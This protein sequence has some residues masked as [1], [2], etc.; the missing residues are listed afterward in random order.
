MIVDHLVTRSAVRSLGLVCAA[1]VPLATSYLL[2][3]FTYKETPLDT[4]IHHV[5]LVFHL[6]QSGNATQITTATVTG[7]GAA[8]YLYPTPATFAASTPVSSISSFDSMLGLSPDLIASATAAM[9][10]TGPPS[11][12]KDDTFALSMT[13]RMTLSLATFLEGLG[14]RD[15]TQ[16]PGYQHLIT[17]QPYLAPIVAFIATHQTLAWVVSLLHLW[18]AAELLFY[19]HFW[20]RLARAQQVDRVVK[21]PRSPEERR[22]LFERCMET[23]ERGAGAR[24]WVETWFDT[25]RT[26]RPART[27]DIARSNM[28]QWLAWA[29]WAS[30]IEEVFGSPSDMMEL[31]RMVDYI[32]ATKDIKFAIGFNPN[33][34]CIRLAFDPVIASHRPLVYYALVW[35]ANTFAGLVFTVLGFTRFEGTVDTTHPPKKNRIHQQVVDPSTDLNYWYYAPINP[36]NKVPLVFLH[37]I[38]VGLIQYIHWVVAL[39]TISRPIIMVE[40]PYVSNK[41]IKGDCMTPDD[42]YFAI[43]R[44]LRR[45]EYP[46]A[47]FFGHSLGTMLCAAVCRASPASSPKSIVAG[48]ILADPICFLTHHSI[49][50]NFAYRIPA[51]A[52]ELVMDL[53]A[54]REIGT[55]WYIMRR[56]HWDQCI[57]F[58]KAWKKRTERSLLYEGRLSPVLPKK[59]RIFLSRNDNLLNMDTIAEYIRNQVGLKEEKDELHIMEGMDHAQFLLRPDWFFKVLKAAEEC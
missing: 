4:L 1:V 42:T 48:L 36:D 11:S 54:A 40:V 10:G 31:N 56:F 30:S 2:Y 43:E 5:P 19:I 8:S 37:G 23:V 25:G 35:I 52:A 47:T 20:K 16:L 3:T 38:G 14:L 51:T 44:I 58:P 32:E 50:R 29:F 53:F 9:F 46:K 24:K 28:M 33:V 6:L 55:S 41:L 18:I 21:G 22:E 57:F 12:S 34:E 27:E 15:P 7:A 45:H 13:M 26:D 49:A 59:T 17:L 39:S